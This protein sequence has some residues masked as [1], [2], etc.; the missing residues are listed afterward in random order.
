MAITPPP[1]PIVTS[2]GTQPI[3][4][5]DAKLKVAW[6]DEMKA[7]NKYVRHKHVVALLLFWENTEGWSD[8]HTEEEVRL[9][10]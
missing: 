2:T 10:N 3:Q 8:M 6:E 1:T 4:S 7:V 5:E 9:S